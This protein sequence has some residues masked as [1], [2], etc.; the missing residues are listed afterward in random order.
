MVATVL[1]KI[2]SAQE[3]HFSSHLKRLLIISEGFEERSIS[4]L[5]SFSTVEFSK[6]LICRYFPK[7]IAKY[8]ELLTLLSCRTPE[9]K[10][11]SFNRYNPFEF[12]VLLQEE[13]AELAS[14]DE[15]VIDLSVMSKYMIMQI[16]C[17]LAY[18]S[19][20]IKIIY[21]EPV[22][23]APSQKEYEHD[24]KDK[25]QEF[26]T[27]LPSYGVYDI[28]RTPLLTSLVMQKSP[29]LLI[30]FLSFNE[31][32]IRALLSEFNPTRLYL[33][34]G[35]PP[36]L[37]WREKAMQDI[38]LNIIKEYQ[39][40]NQ[41]DDTGKLVRRVSTLQYEETFNLI[42]DVYRNNCVSSRI[43]LAP[44][45]SKMQAV[46]CALLKLCCLDIH[47]EYPTPESYYI[48]GYSSSEIKEIHLLEFS[49]FSTFISALADS[50]ELNR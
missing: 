33:I 37:S 34:N 40:D 1:P 24:I 17:S 32:L 12:E 15:I 5:S 18:Y 31:Q 11:L 13:L 45:G 29:S 50:A 44:T 16:I 21:T 14:F 8:D 28:V 36:L 48:E 39:M 41:I 43:V 25:G 35:V 7:K 27:V 6:A 47:I 10:E 20:N 19:G 46:A 3:G 42:S 4:F 26:A 30:S 2:S 49:N 38:H 22:S 23:Y 9:I